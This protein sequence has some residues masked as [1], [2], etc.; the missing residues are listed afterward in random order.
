MVS[1]SSAAPRTGRRDVQAAVSWASGR[2]AAARGHS[3]DD[4]S[5]GA[6]VTRMPASASDISTWQDRRECSLWCESSDS[7]S[8]SSDI[9]GGSF[10]AYRKAFTARGAV[11][12]GPRARVPSSRELIALRRRALATVD[13]G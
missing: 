7:S 10:A 8:R 13:A 1:D 6:I 9:A 12:T 5:S 4:H 11:P 2:C 3:P